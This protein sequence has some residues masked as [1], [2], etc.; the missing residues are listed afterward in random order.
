M[1]PEH[2]L[3]E[4]NLVFRSPK[5]TQVVLEG[6]N[7]ESGTAT[8]SGCKVECH[9]VNGIYYCKVKCSI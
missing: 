1:S 7:T 6:L 2:S 8:T 4:D 9:I 3:T 5:G